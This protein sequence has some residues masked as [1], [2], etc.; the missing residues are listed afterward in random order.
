MPAI[1]VVNTTSAPQPQYNR[2]VIVVTRNRRYR[3]GFSIF[4]SLMTLA[5][6]Y[7]VYYYAMRIRNNVAASVNAAEHSGEH[8]GEHGGEHTP[9]PAE[10]KKK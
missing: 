7:G 6:I 8:A 10:H 4:G 3:S 9:P 2:P 5:I 1:V